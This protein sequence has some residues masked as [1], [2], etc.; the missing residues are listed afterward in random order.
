MTAMSL[1]LVIH[2]SL[3]IE[4]FTWSHFNFLSRL[5][6]SETFLLAWFLMAVLGVKP[7][8]VIMPQTAWP[9]R[10]TPYFFLA[11]QRPVYMHALFGAFEDRKCP[12]NLQVS[13]GNDGDM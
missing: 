7:M 13:K 8:I 10:A 1:F 4:I 9:R 3:G 2:W 12:W 6:I 5:I 11:Q